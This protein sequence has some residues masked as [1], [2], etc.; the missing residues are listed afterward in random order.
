MKRRKEGN[1]YFSS[2][3]REVREKA[4]MYLPRFDEGISLGVT[5]Q[6]VLYIP[7]HSSHA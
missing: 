6:L 3:L 7:Y 4:R 1:K 5:S 2:S